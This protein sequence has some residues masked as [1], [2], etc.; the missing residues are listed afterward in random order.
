MVLINILIYRRQLT[1]TEKSN[2]I[3]AVKCLMKKPSIYGAGTNIPGAV[4]RYD[5][6]HGV[7]ISQTMS[8]HFVV[9]YR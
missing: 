2:Y 6:F 1:T 4:N 3:A 7:H 9:C 8:I 5:D